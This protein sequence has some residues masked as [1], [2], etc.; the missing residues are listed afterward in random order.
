MHPCACMIWCVMLPVH[1]LMHY[2]RHQGEVF[3]L[4]VGVNEK[5]LGHFYALN[6]GGWGVVTN[7]TWLRNLAKDVSKQ[8]G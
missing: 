7:E 2:Q 8:V 3:I 1:V 4:T 5:G 6:K